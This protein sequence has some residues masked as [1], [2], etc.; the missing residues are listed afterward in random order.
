M[1]VSD[2]TSRC[3]SS[4]SNVQKFRAMLTNFRRRHCLCTDNNTVPCRNFAYRQTQC[5]TMGFYFPTHPLF[6]GRDQRELT[7]TAMAVDR[8]SALQYSRTDD[9][10]DDL[11]SHGVEQ[12]RLANRWVGVGTDAEQ[13][14]D[15]LCCTPHAR[16]TTRTCWQGDSVQNR[17]FSL[18]RPTRTP[19][20]G[21][22]Y[23]LAHSA[24]VERHSAET[25]KH[26]LFNR[27]H[28]RRRVAFPNCTSCPQGERESVCE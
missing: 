16:P 14:L 12:D 19:D 15:V 20:W 25:F 7:F 18:Q 24:A 28:F 22:H 6:V 4:A 21:S 8:R 10:G 2:V 1:W 26:A 11:A 17:A 27:W 3:S 13:C 9:D 23:N 5:R